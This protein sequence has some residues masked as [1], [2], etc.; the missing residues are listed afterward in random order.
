MSDKKPVA[1][2]TDPTPEP[3]NPADVTPAP[4][5]DQEH[6][7]EPNLEPTNP[8]DVP[9]PTG[10]GHTVHLPS[11]ISD[12]YGMASM[13]ARSTLQG[14]RVYFDGEE[15]TG[16]DKI[17]PPLEKIKDKEVTVNGEFRTVK[18]TYSG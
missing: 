18:F 1:G 7:Q 17:D 14:A 2:Q 6:H 12:L 4:Q 3:A 15:V 16:D 11:I 5:A 10:D 9:Q 8:S 13:T